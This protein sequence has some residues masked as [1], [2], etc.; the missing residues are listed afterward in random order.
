MATGGMTTPAKQQVAQM[1]WYKTLM[2]GERAK[3]LNSYLHM[4]VIQ[5]F[6]SSLC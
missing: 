4:I 3:G 5:T 1:K 2:M 6:Q